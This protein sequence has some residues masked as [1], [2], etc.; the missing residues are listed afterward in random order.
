MHENGPKMGLKCMKMEESVP[1]GALRPKQASWIRRRPRDAEAQRRDS[2]EPKESEPE[3]QE[4]A[5]GLSKR[6]KRS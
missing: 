6:V 2:L 5:R 3:V 4:P 1:Q